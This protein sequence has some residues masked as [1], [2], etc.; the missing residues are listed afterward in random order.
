[1]KSQRKPEYERVIIE[2]GTAGAGYL[3]TKAYE[4]TGNEKY[5]EAAKETVKYLLGIAVKQKKG[6]FI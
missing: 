2:F 3:F 1:M 6:Y 5:I 4:F